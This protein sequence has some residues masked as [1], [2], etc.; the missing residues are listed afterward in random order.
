VLN[1]KHM[2]FFVHSDANFAMSEGGF[3]KPINQDALVTQILFMG[4]LATD[5]RRKQGKLQGIT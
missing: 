4:N 3:Q 2:H 1:S 5:N